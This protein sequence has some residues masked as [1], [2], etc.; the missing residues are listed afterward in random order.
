MTGFKNRAVRHLS[1]ACDYTITL[2]VLLCELYQLGTYSKALKYIYC[3]P[4]SETDPH[5]YICFIMMAH[6]VP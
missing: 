1:A 5:S 4:H 2:S 6:C 3:I